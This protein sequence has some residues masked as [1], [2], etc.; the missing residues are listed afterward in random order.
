MF[1]T[2]GA[3]KQGRDTPLFLT[4]L[5]ELRSRLGRNKKIHVICDSATCHTSDGVAVYLWEHRDRIE[6]HVL[7]KYSPDRN[8]IERVWWNTMTGS[9]ATTSA[10]RCRSSWT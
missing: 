5:N 1:I 4:H 7:P 8:P 6:M 9:R 2:Q 10:S 3:E